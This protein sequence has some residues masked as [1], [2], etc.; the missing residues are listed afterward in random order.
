[1]TQ[2]VFCTWGCF[3]Q[4]TNV[5]GLLHIYSV[6]LIFAVVARKLLLPLFLFVSIQGG[7]TSINTD[8][9]PSITTS[10]AS[11]ASRASDVGVCVL[12]M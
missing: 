12:F 11:L 5:L 1:M 2:N 4:D 10:V 6:F 9:T 7:D 3:H 8:Q